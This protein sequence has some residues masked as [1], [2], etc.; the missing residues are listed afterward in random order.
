MPSVTGTEFEPCATCC[1]NLPRDW[2][3]ARRRGVRVWVQTW[4]RAA[5]SY[6]SLFKSA[7]VF[8]YIS[9]DAGSKNT[10]WCPVCGS[11]F[12]VGIPHF[13]TGSLIRTL[14]FYVALTTRSGESVATVLTV[15]CSNSGT[16]KS[17][18]TS[19]KRPYLLRG[20]SSP[21][22]PLPLLRQGLFLGAVKR[23]KV[24]FDRCPPPNA[25][26]TILIK[27]AFMARTWKI[28]R[29]QLWGLRLTFRK[30]LA[31]CFVHDLTEVFLYF[32]LSCKANARV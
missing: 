6:C 31:L 4:S 20:S 30:I 22:P 29:L 7:A 8:K 5:D 26:V 3:C 14:K 17:L 9:K 24:E 11:R 28:L 1:T 25:K 15:R 2:R 18:F 19:R 27:Y 23:L 32:F 16:G 13:E 12:E 10:I 21:L